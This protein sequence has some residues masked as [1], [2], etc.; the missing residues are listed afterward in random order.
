MFTAKDLKEALYTVVEQA[1]KDYVYQG[2]KCRY[3]HYGEPDCGIARALVLLGMPIEELKEWDMT[4]I[5]QVP[6]QLNFEARAVASAFQ[7]RQDKRYA[8]GDCLE[9]AMHVYLLLCDY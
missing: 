7:R 1:G 4:P 5:A 3:V 9:A 6:T 8:W 2:D